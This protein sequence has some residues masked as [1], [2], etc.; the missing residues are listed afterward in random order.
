[1]VNKT[2]AGILSEI[3]TLMCG[4]GKSYTAAGNRSHI[5]VYTHYAISG[6]GGFL[7]RGS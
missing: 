3:L 6:I 2:V 7:S 5:Y 4:V 1:M